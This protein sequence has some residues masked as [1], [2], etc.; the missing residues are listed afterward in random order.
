MQVL[1]LGKLNNK[2]MKKVTKYS[3]ELLIIAVT[4]FIFFGCSKDK[5]KPRDPKRCVEGFVFEDCNGNVS[6]GRK[7]VLQYI[8][9]GGWGSNILSE[10][11]TLTNDNGKFKFEYKEAKSSKSSISYYHTLT[12]ENSRISITNPSGDL[13]LYPN[14]TLMNA[15]INL[16]FR[17]PYTANDTFYYQFKPS[18]SGFVEE[19]EQISYLVG[20]FQD[21]TIILKNLRIGNTN[22][23]DKGQGYC[24]E[25]KWGISKRRLNS[26]YTGKDGNFMFTHEPC[27]ENDTFDYYAE[28]IN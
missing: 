1:Y 19:A 5:S 17:N 9:T 24:G 12:I 2:G 18:P 28:P 16:K 10:E 11:S 8:S 22:N 14:D 4:P 25:F 26:Y 20:P 7:V 3:K 6:K 23:I 13:N 21:T 15:I 27:N